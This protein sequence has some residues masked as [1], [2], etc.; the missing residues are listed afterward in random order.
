[1]L[2]RRS[3]LG[4]ILALGVVPA[5]VRGDALMRIVP[6]N[7]G[8][9][10]G[11]T[12]TP[13]SP[14]TTSGKYT[15]LSMPPMP[16]DG[17]AVAP[18]MNG[19]TTKHVAMVEVAPGKVAAYAGD[20]TGAPYVDSYRQDAFTLD[21]ASN[22]WTLRETYAK[23]GLK[24][25]RPDTMGI[26]WD[27]LKS[28]ILLI[29]GILS[30]SPPPPAGAWAHHADGTWT[31]DNGLQWGTGMMRG[32]CM[33]AHTRRWIAVGESATLGSV[34]RDYNI[35]DWSKATTTPWPGA[36]GTFQTYV[37]Q[38][39]PCIVGRYVYFV[40]QTKFASG[41]P[42]QVRFYRWN[43][44]ARG[45]VQRL[46]DPPVANSTPE[47]TLLAGSGTKVVWPHILGPEGVID[48]MLVYDVAT[49]KWVADAARPN[50]PA[51]EF[52]MN[53]LCALA[54][55]RVLMGGSAFN[56]TRQRHIFIYRP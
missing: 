10:G 51:T 40:A 53:S 19:Q 9:S 16:S 22:T 17:H 5:M 4:S 1:M 32:G 12:S 23:A 27:A 46:A 38:S 45:P 30:E 41:A 55:G 39:L 37:D 36:D 28:R 29:P 26:A 3:I 14:P 48:A 7:P 47:S 44:D 15:V 34:V 52:L 18:F 6:P 56:T 35:D 25:K 20:F 11:G 54:D 49:D 8:P 24:P 21:L 43:I 42:I 2:T 33:D 50:V 31:V 13:G